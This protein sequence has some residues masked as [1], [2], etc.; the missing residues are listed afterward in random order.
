MRV[1]FLSLCHLLPPII[2]MAGKGNKCIKNCGRRVSHV[3]NTCGT[4]IKAGG[5]ENISNRQTITLC[6]SGCGSI[7]GCKG[8]MC[9]NCWLQGDYVPSLRRGRR[10]VEW[11]HHRTKEEKQHS[12]RWKKRE[13]FNA[14]AAEYE[15]LHSNVDNSSRAQVNAV[16]VAKSKFTNLLSAIQT[17]NPERII[18][19]SIF[20]A[21]EGRCHLVLHEGRQSSLKQGSSTP[22]I[23]KLEICDGGTY[24]RSLNP[25][26]RKTIGPDVVD[27]YDATTSKVIAN[28]V[29]WKVQLHVRDVLPDNVKLLQVRPG[30]GGCQGLPPYK[31][32]AR[33][34]V[35]DK[36]G[37]LPLGAIL[38]SVIPFGT[39]YFS[40]CE[41]NASKKQRTLGEYFGKSG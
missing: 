8:N 18:T 21:S 9:L 13:T 30:T 2:R 25:N 29:E 36:H 19:T 33:F 14:V 31:V 3:G 4:C 40:E 39:E 12:L 15:S 7:V 37:N 34:I 27:I 16:D 10:I 24:W 32:G 1:V 38:K 11:R 20:V 6:I 17:Q 35:H 5:K 22:S 28:H 41:K 26:E 23:V